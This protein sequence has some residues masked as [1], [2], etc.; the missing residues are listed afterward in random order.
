MDCHTCG[1]ENPA[2]YEFCGHCRADL[3]RP[4]EGQPAPRRRRPPQ[5]A[6]A[7]L[8]CPR[9]AAQNLDR[10]RYCGA[11]GYDLRRR[12]IPNL[13]PPPPFV[14]RLARFLALLVVGGVFLIAGVGA[15]QS[16][17][18]SPGIAAFGGLAMLILLFSSYA[19]W[20]MQ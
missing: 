2:R 20:R 19:R 5:I 18:N 9:C 1:V 15:I 3:R 7:P 6:G 17:T 13:L 11:C 14:T 16:L 10:Q 4:A 12:N 8:P